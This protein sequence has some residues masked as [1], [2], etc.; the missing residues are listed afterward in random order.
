MSCP[1]AGVLFNVLMPGWLQTILLTLLLLVVINKTARKG[2]SQWRLEQRQHAKQEPADH[3][4]EQ[5]LHA[6]EGHKHRGILHEESFHGHAHDGV[7]GRLEQAM[8]AAVQA[9]D[10]QA[11][12]FGRYLSQAWGRL[13]FLK[14]CLWGAQMEI[15]CGR[16]SEARISS[17]CRRE[18]CI[19]TS[20]LM[21]QQRSAQPKHM[22]VR[23]FPGR[24]FA[25]HGMQC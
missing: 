2:L 7:H 20:P 4:N 12:S 1:F 18:R 23:H 10:E 17:C 14:V 6:S 16:D 11:H 24:C 21:L 8:D 25:A 15:P 19:L 3:N 5:A 22:L 9:V 13:P